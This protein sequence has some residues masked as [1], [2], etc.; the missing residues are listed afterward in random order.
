MNNRRCSL[1]SCD[2]FVFRDRIAFGKAHETTV[3]WH[4]HV[5]FL[6]KA[7]RTC[8]ILKHRFVV[9]TYLKEGTTINV[10]GQNLLPTRDLCARNYGFPARYKH[11][12][13]LTQSDFSAASTVCFVGPS[14]S[15][16]VTRALWEKFTS[17][18]TVTDVCRR[19]FKVK[20]S[21]KTLLQGWLHEV[22]N[23]MG[24]PSHCRLCPGTYQGTYQPCIIKP[25]R[26]E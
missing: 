3:D 25:V 24:R 5:I 8:T 17:A 26:S 21:R 12:V 20:G 22:A 4:F 6:G 19:H 10:R 7:S 14:F 2:F 13:F 15:P 1:L 18:E 23:Y 16:F 9:G 11:T